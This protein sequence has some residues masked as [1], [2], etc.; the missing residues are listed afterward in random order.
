LF[1]VHYCKFPFVLFHFWVEIDRYFAEE[2]LIGINN[3]HFTMFWIE[4]QGCSNKQAQPTALQ[5]QEIVFKN[6]KL[7][8]FYPST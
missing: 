2:L 6:I 4:R 5:N 7:S 8:I 3:I 1:I